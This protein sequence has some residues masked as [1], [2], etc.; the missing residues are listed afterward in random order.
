MKFNSTKDVLLKSV[1]SVQSAISAKSS[2][3]ILSNILIEATND[4]VVMTTTDLDIGIISSTPIKPNI[5]GSITVP[6]KKFSDIIKEL[7]DN[8]AISIHVKKNN[9]VNI[10]CDKNSFKIMGLPK[11]EFPQLPEFKD[12]NHITLQQKKLK[13]MLRMTS[14]AISSDETRYVLNGILFVIKPA[15]IRLVATD[16]RCLAMIEEKMQLPKTIERKLILPTKA[17]YELDKVLGDE[18]EVKMFLGDNQVLFDVGATKL[19]SRL[20]EGEFPPYERV[21]PEEAK[22]K[23]V[24]ARS[25]FLSAIK[26][27]ALF[28]NADS[29]VIRVDLQKDKMV[30]SKSATYLGEARVE[31]DAAYKGKEMSVG[32]NP[33]YIIDLLKNI[34][35]ESVAFELTDPEKPG[36]VRIGDEYV[37][38]IMPM[39]LG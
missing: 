22:E 30:L 17:V 14:F 8:E 1:Q 7:P 32:F 37:Y 25:A 36:A 35:Q 10:D 33:T 27:V 21:V 19:I 15:S 28:A 4:D 13:S 38:V 6:A 5:A 12:K 39:H 16:G 11:E 18:G 9:L 31:V 2:L 3:P 34:D 20:I 26:R 24:V 29:M 23:V